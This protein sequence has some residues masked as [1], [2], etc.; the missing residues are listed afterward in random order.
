VHPTKGVRFSMY[1]SARPKDLVFTAAEVRALTLD[2]TVRHWGTRDGSG[3]PVDLPVRDYVERWVYDR[4]FLALATPALDPPGIDAQC[5]VRE[6]Y[7]GAHVVA[8]VAPGDDPDDTLAWR[9]LRVVLEV[10]GEG[11]EGIRLVGVMHDEWRI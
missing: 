2:T 7:P 10:D 8:F 5:N 1:R 6:V 3:E 11:A 4:D 9:G